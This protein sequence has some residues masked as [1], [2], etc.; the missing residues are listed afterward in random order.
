[1]P[2]RLLRPNS[3][4][5]PLAEVVILD[6][7][8]DMLESISDIVRLK[9]HVGCLTAT[10]LEALKALGERALACRVAIIDINLGADQPSGIDAYRWLQGEHFSG[11][12]AFLT[13]HARSHP[14]V[15]EASTLGMVQ[16]IEKPAPIETLLQFIG[17]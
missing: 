17:G 8:Q 1:M 15:Q 11:K 9:S 16:I 7:D 2:A 4:P 10:S 6:D 3:D 14:L 5:A 12:I 13:G